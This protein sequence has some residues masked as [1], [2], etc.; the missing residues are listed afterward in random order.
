MTGWFGTPLGKRAWM[1][2]WVW[3]GLDI[4]ACM[5]G[6]WCWGGFNIEVSRLEV[7]MTGWFCDFVFW[8]CM[9]LLS[10]WVPCQSSVSSSWVSFSKSD[11]VSV[12]SLCAPVSSSPALLGRQG[13]EADSYLPS[14]SL[15]P[16]LCSCS[17]SSLMECSSLLSTHPFRAV[18]SISLGIFK[19]E[20]CWIT[21]VV[22]GW[23][24]PPFFSPSQGWEAAAKVLMTS[25]PWAPNLGS[26]SGIE[27]G[28]KEMESLDA[29]V[30]TGVV[31]L[32]SLDSASSPIPSWWLQKDSG[33]L[34]VGTGVSKV[35][36]EALSLGQAVTS[37]T[38]QIS[39]T[40]A[41][42]SVAGGDSVSVFGDSDGGRDGFEDT[43]EGDGSVSGV[44]VWGLSVESTLDSCSCAPDEWE[45]A[46]DSCSSK[47]TLPPRL[48]PPPGSMGPGCSLER[49]PL[50]RS[51][52]P[53]PPPGP[54]PPG[55]PP[56]PEAAT[57][58]AASRWARA[59]CARALMSARVRAPV[60]ER[61]DPSLGGTMRGQIWYVGG[62]LTQGGLIR[63]S[64]I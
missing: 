1:T 46:G 9:L 24:S 64:C 33:S 29:E 62:P 36:S 25:T 48:P 13:R 45:L 53:V 43:E 21:P 42:L 60:P 28:T 10:I 56:S 5:T 32:L 39:S 44:E 7:W 38:P 2:V 37:S 12:E 40:E 41:G 26:E 58:A 52:I 3:L 54:L 63:E 51:G 18:T 34:G 19:S 50:E 61:R 15:P 4:W 35:C 30:Q 14:A 47:S 6:C 20:P 16:F 23:C 31:V 11:A 57:A 17:I 8:A 59:C 49:L 22:P 27:V 55:P